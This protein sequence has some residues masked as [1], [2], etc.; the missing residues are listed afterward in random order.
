VPFRVFG[1]TARFGE[2][3]SPTIL[4]GLASPSE[5]KPRR[6]IALIA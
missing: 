2:L 3:H 4:L 6:S 5:F 1:L